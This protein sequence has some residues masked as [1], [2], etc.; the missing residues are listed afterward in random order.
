M[1]PAEFVLSQNYPNP[2][3]PTTTITF[4]L[5]EEGY[6]SLKVFDVLGREV[7]ALVNAQLKAGVVHHAILD[8]SQLSC[9]IYFYRLEVGKN[10]Q[11]K[12]LMLLK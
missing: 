9:G 11:V 12:K 6:V 5:A 10:V 1:K 2:F 3:N 7:V 8:A 4:T